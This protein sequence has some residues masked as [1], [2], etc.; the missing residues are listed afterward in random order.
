MISPTAYLF[1]TGGII[2]P[3][4]A[5]K[6]MPPMHKRAIPFFGPQPTNSVRSLQNGLSLSFLVERFLNKSANSLNFAVA[7]QYASLNYG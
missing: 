4:T 2:F 6:M 1:F 3:S 5:M 7:K